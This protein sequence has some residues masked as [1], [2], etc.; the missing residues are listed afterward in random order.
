MNYILYLFN[1][2]HP[3]TNGLAQHTIPNLQGYLFVVKR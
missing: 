3:S 2:I 1:D